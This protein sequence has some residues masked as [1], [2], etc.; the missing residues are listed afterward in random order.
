[1]EYIETTDLMPLLAD[2]AADVRIKTAT[3]VISR[4]LQAVHYAHTSGIVHRDI[5]PGNILAYREGKRLQIKLA[6][7]G[8]AKVYQDAGLSAMTNERSVRGTLAY[9]APEQF[10]NSRDAGPSVDLFACGSCLFRLLTGEVPNVVLKP[11]R[12]EEVLS[13]ATSL[14]DSLKDVL[15]R[16]IASNPADRYESAEAMV[17]ALLPFH[18]RR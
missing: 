2:Q 12:T 13:A 8:L 5:K 3:W 18:G 16:S 17:S 9:M 14:P 7:F 15:R 4:V 10:R 6:D 11:A 1:M